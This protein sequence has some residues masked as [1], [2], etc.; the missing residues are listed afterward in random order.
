MVDSTSKETDIN[1]V[2]ADISETEIQGSDLYSVPINY[3]TTFTPFPAET[4]VKSNLRTLWPR[5]TPR[6][7]LSM[8]PTNPQSQKKNRNY[9]ERVT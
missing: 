9:K 5:D 7:V 4:Q 2:N 1:G 6:E 3:G 8:Q